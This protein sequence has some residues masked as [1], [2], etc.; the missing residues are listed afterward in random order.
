M[1]GNFSGTNSSLVLAPGWLVQNPLTEAALL[2]EM[3]TME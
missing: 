2:E 1:Q 3:E